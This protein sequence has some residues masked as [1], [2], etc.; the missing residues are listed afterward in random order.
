MLS[1]HLAGDEAD[2]FAAFVERHAQFA[3]RVA[4]ARLRHAANA[5]DAVQEAFLKLM[6]KCRWRAAENERAF[7]ATAV[8]RAAGDLAA[9][10]SLEST[11]D[12]ALATV[13]AAG[14]TPEQEAVR[15]DG[16]ARMHRLIGALPEGLRAPLVLS[17]LD[18]LTAREVAA[19][20]RLP[21]GTVRRRIA[22][23]RSLLREK[24]KGM[25]VHR[26]RTR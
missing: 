11:D 18:E 5:E 17:A 19:V 21:E 14:C 24:W 23:A 15:T 1:E 8:W 3:Y 10:S 7:L 20:L 4:F 25:E 13:P 16:E 2:A 22:E 12:A 26:E 6:A 9:S